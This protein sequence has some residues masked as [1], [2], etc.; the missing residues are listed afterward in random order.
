MFYLGLSL[1]AFV[2]GWSFAFKKRGLFLYFAISL[3]III[4][5][6]SALGDTWQLGFMYF[7][8]GC[9]GGTGAEMLFRFVIKKGA[10]N[11]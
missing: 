7:F 3:I 5:L 8:I 4:L 10:K 1:L 11:E 2:L 6:K 9:C